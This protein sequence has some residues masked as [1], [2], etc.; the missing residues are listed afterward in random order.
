[1]NEETHYLSIT[2]VSA[3]LRARKISPVEVLD[4]CLARIER[5]NLRLNG[6]VTVLS[7]QARVDATAAEAE[8]VAGR[9]RG[10]LHGVPIG[11]KEFYDTANIRTTAAFEGFKNRIPIPPRLD[12]CI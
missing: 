6:F 2:Q 5:L 11:I 4:R 10:P 9:W 8:I 1:M 3:L 12:R 7:D